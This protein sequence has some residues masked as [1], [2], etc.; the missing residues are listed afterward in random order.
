MA[1]I[2]IITKSNNINEIEINKSIKINNTNNEIKISNEKQK[3]Q[4]PIEIINSDNINIFDKLLDKLDKS[5][6]IV[7][8]CVAPHPPLLF[9]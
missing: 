7:A 8:I 5:P 9:Q 2:G 1:V 3:I 4:Y 6:V